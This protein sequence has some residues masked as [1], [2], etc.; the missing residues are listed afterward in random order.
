MG[1]AQPRDGGDRRLEGEMLTAMV[2]REKGA[3]ER[4]GAQ[5]HKQLTHHSPNK[6]L[7]TRLQAGKASTRR[8]RKGREAGKQDEGGNEAQ[9]V[10]LK[11]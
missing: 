9:Q 5:A 1:S 2:A 6:N 4:G 7:G 8:G 3:K 10:H 11:S